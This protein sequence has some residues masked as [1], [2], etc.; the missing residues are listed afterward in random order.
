MH[1]LVNNYMRYIDWGPDGANP[2]VLT[3]KDYDK[4][5]G[6]GA[7]F[8]RK[9]ESGCSSQLIDLLSSQ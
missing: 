1:T 6:S 9:M 7:L 5:V 8:T 3:E 4:I 2:Q